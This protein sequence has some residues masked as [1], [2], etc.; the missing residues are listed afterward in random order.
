MRTVLVIED[1]MDM[2][3]IERAT[4]DSAGYHV[5]L[6]A[7]GQ[8]GL[9]LLQAQRPCVIVLDLMMPVMDGLTFL[10]EQRKRRIAEDV[11][12]LCI[13]A[14]G[15]EMQKHALTLGAPE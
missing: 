13:T 12:V 9:Q 5:M 6:A 14:A 7:N 4:L 11:P 2:R 1:D 8:E 15:H 3:E 10:A